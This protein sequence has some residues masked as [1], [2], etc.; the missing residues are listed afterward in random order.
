MSLLFLAYANHQEAPLASLQREYEKVH[1][2]LSPGIK[3]QHFDVHRELYATID[4]VSYSLTEYRDRISIFCYSGHADQDQLIFDGEEAKAEGIANLLKQCPNL[5]CVFLNGCSTQG[6]VK[7]LL[8]LGIPVVIATSA[9]VNDTIATD[10]GIRFY[11]SLANGDTITQAFEQAKGTALSKKDELSIDV[12]K[13]D[14]IFS[15]EGESIA[16]SWGLFVN[17]GRDEALTWKL[18]SRRILAE[19]IRIKPNEIL[20]EVLLEA[21][22]EYREDAKAIV[23]KG[24][25]DEEDIDPFA[26]EEEE[27]VELD[28][29][30]LDKRDAILNNLPYIISEQL[31]K[32]LVEPGKD[33]Q[34]TFYHKFGADRLRQIL[35]TYNTSVEL[36]GFIMMAQYWELL[37]KKDQ[38]DELASLKAF[39]SLPPFER[40]LFDFLPLIKEVHSI[41]KSAD[42]EIYFLEELIKKEDILAES[43]EMREASSY[44]NTLRDRYQD[45][46]PEEQEAKS[47]SVTAEEKL[48]IFLKHLAFLSNYELVS[49]IDIGL[50]KYRHYKAPKFN[51]KLIHLQHRVSG[52]VAVEE[53][54]SISMDSASVIL[55]RREGKSD[56]FLN[57]SPFVIDENAFKDK[58]NLAKLHFFL[59]YDQGQKAFSYKHIYKPEDMPLVVD[60]HKSYFKD[61][62]PQFSPFKSYMTT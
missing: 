31:R 46:M 26:M 6:W 53:K 21:L 40:D 30:D 50:L 52:T 19:D 25:T 47:I 54:M 61:L 41:L 37:Q 16:P 28:D 49:I 14:F 56:A 32:L 35:H 15:R 39:F 10:F 60:K 57:L 36:L 62:G 3:G 43:S 27:T 4:N 45:A 24:S 33:T 18:P 12:H 59:R 8:E 5:K 17:E 44:L 7:K 11:Q 38:N 20:I 22:A 23:Q 13:G 48:A 34:Q 1:E 29:T 42:K 58:G 55:S 51:H 9:P 2:Y